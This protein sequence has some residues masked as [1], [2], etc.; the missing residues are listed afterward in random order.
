MK[1]EIIQAGQNYK[2]LQKLKLP[3]QF[4]NMLLDT[5][6][7]RWIY[8]YNLPYEPAVTDILTYSRH[9]RW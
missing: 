4:C 3:V 6:T 5:N 7:W 9:G 2:L 8:P 1:Y